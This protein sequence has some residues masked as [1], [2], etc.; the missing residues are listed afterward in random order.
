MKFEGSWQVFVLMM[1]NHAFT[2]FGKVVTSQCKCFLSCINKGFSCGVFGFQIGIGEVERKVSIMLMLQFSLAMP[3]LGGSQFTRAQSFR[4]G[5]SLITLCFLSLVSVGTSRA[6][7]GD[8][9]STKVHGDTYTVV[10]IVS[11]GTSLSGMR[12]FSTAVRDHAG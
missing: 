5:R 7:P 4:L 1:S 6:L 9:G 12:C 8:R 2:C 3:S 10:V 11:W